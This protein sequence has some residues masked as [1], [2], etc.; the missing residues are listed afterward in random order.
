[1]AKQIKIGSRVMWRGGWGRD[2]AVEAKVERIEETDEPHDTDGREVD[3]ID[4]ENRER[5]VIDLDNGHWCY[6]DQIVEV[7]DEE[8][9]VG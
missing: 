4:F 3:S 6:G 8:K 9:K 2:P 7:L 5:S 1:M